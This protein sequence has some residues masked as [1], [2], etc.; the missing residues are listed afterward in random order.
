MPVKPQLVNDKDMTALLKQ[1][2]PDQAD[3]EDVQAT[4][5]AVAPLHVQPEVMDVAQ[6]PGQ[7]VMP[8]LK[9]HKA[10]ASDCC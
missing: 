10:L 2:T 1:A 9:A 3:V 7:L 8:A 4:L 5:E 6:V